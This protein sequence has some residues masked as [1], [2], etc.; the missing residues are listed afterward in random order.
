MKDVIGLSILGVIIIVVGVMFL[1]AWLVDS[2][3][4]WK[5]KRKKN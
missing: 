2:I 4:A 1:Y 5:R 3:N